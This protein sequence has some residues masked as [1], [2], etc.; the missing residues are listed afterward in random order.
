MFG[1]VKQVASIDVTLWEDERQ[2]VRCSPGAD[3][4]ASA[5]YVCRFFFCID[6]VA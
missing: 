1:C 4:L 2:P 6:E 5:Q 3:N